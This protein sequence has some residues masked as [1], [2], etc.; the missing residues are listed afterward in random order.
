MIDV[1]LNGTPWA[2][3]VTA[4]T[5]VLLMLFG[6]RLARRTGVAWVWLVLFGTALAG[7]LGV[8]ATPDEWIP[9]GSGSRQWLGRVEFPTQPFSLANQATLNAWLAVPMSAL[10]AWALVRRG[11]RW[12]VAVVVVAPLVAEGTQWLF[13]SFGRVAFSLGDL[14][15][16]F[17]GVVFGLALGAAAAGATTLAQRRSA[18][19]AEQPA[20]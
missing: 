16:N 13:P 7:F 12:P 15:C 10:A 18:P 1:Y 2:V 3:P 17:T 19:V 8:I 4:A 5:F 11:R 14:T 9:S 20:A 6:R